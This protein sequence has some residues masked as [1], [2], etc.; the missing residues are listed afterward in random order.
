MSF[1]NRLDELNERRDQG[2][3]EI[4]KMHD[5]GSQQI[6]DMQDQGTQELDDLQDQYEAEL[7]QMQNEGDAYEDEGDCYDRVQAE[8]EM[9][10]YY[11]LDDNHDLSDGFEDNDGYY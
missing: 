7:N 11:G 1:Q 4:D 5:Q 9:Q 6:E 10:L 8:A 3:E 2:Q